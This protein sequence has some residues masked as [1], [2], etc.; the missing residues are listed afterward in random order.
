LPRSETPPFFFYNLQNHSVIFMFE[1]SI[2]TIDMMTYFREVEHDQN[3]VD[4]ISDG[5]VILV[6]KGIQLTI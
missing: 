5:A 3:D 4:V 6:S 2:Y 1:Q